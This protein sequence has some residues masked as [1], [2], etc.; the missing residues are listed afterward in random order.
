LK[1]AV[2]V[3]FLF[4]ILLPSSLRAW[5]IN[6]YQVEIHVEK[7]SDLRVSERIVVDFGGER[8]HGIYRDIP[9]IFRDPLGKKHRLRIKEISVSDDMARPRKVKLFRRGNWLKIR[10]G[11]TNKLISGIQTYVIDYRV[12]YALYHINEV[13]E[14]YWNAIGTGWAVPIKKAEAT[15]FLPIEDQDIQVACYTGARGSRARNCTWEREGSAIRFT[16]TH[17][18][19]PH[20]GLTVAVGWPPGLVKIE[21]G[22]GILGSP[23]FHVSLYLAA[24][25][26]LLYWLWRTRGRDIGGRG[27]I[28]VQYHPPEDMTP[29]EAGCLID[30][31]MDMRDVVAEIVDLARRGYLTIEE[32]EEEGF[33]FGKKRD[34]I[35]YRQKGGKGSLHNSPYD[36]TL[37]SALFHMGDTQRLSGLKKKFYEHLP[38]I[39]D[40]VFSML[41]RKGYFLHNPATVRNTYR[42]I[43][44]TVAILTVIGFSF[45]GRFMGTPPAPIMV[46]GM[47]T[48]ALLIAFGQIMP[49]KTASG[50]LAWEH[51]KGYEEFVSRVE[52]PVIEKLFSPEEIPRV[53]EEALPYAIAF[54]EAERWATAFEGLFQEPPRW[55]RT[56]GPY[57]PIYLGHSMDHF[58]REAATAL[59]SAPRSSGSGGGG[60]A[61]GGGGGGGGGAW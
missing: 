52:R 3:F 50:R 40:S 17:P 23:W 51:L 48:A 22:P 33:L 19:Y 12:K 41:K 37:L 6:E 2:A 30:E 54:G 31:R 4:A 35:F 11:R 25:F 42:A 7:S 43:G 49:R 61:G 13:D 47:G 27:V 44:V 8:R 34:Y 26:A 55:Y 29:L 14:L 46:A 21:T 53:F 28:Q 1:R 32:V 56:Y 20:E 36:I 45:A 58:S 5:V 15:V 39:R 18:L 9:L 59:A 38:T 24:L 10:I 60:F 16:V 57:S